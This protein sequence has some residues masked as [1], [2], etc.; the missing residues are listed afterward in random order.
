MK[1][2]HIFV[3][4]STLL[5]VV[6]MCSC[7]QSDDSKTIFGEWSF[8]GIAEKESEY[9]K[10]SIIMGEELLNDYGVSV[11]PEMTIK[12]TENGAKG[13]FDKVPGTEVG[14][15]EWINDDQLRQPIAISVLDGETLDEPLMMDVYYTMKDGYL[16]VEEIFRNDSEDE[17][18]ESDISVYK[19]K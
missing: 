4:L 8:C 5:L 2:K 17:P 14:E 15:V 3:L 12:I 6:G 1:S 13:L 10:D 9:C 18:F 16:F 19:K 7:S 11:L